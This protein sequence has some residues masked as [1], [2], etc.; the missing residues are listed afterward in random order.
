MLLLADDLGNLEAGS[1]YLRRRVLPN[2]SPSAIPSILSELADC[3]LIRLYVRDGKSYVH[4][5]RFRQRLRY[6]KGHCPRPPEEIECKDIRQLIVEK[7]DLSQTKDGPKSDSSQQ[8]RS[9]EKRSEEK[10]SEEKHMPRT[11]EKRGARLPS[12]WQVSQEEIDYCKA[13]RPELSP[14]DTAESFRD[15]WHAKAGKDARKMDWGL[16]WRTWVR[17][18]KGNGNGR[19]EF[20]EAEFTRLL[21]ESE[22]AAGR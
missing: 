22:R 15:F 6:I 10:R 5:P 21:E 8:K 14:L 19:Q 7:T 12:D 17:N 3:D 18:T 9:E 2:V 1:G 11:A 13:K 4:I 16:T 20:D